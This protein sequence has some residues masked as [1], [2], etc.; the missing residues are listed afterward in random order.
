MT[1]DLDDLLGRLAET[2]EGRSLDGMEPLVW[3]RVEALRSERL[4]SQLRLGAVAAPRPSGDMAVFTVD[5]S[6]S[7]LV[8]LETGR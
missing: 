3:R 2:P 1:L 6:L 4:M 8:R 5:A 7:P